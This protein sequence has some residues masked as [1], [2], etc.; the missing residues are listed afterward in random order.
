MFIIPKSKDAT[1][2][3][4]GNGWRT[5]SELDFQELIR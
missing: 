3:N 2:A 1:T 5:P 4:W